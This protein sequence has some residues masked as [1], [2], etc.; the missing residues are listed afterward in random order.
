M[1]KHGQLDSVAGVDAK[2][3]LDCVRPLCLQS[4]DSLVV[5]K[6][7]W[8]SRTGSRS[9]AVLDLRANDRV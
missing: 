4:F 8:R 2:S 5:T 6:L 7:R 9:Q 3:A 1:C